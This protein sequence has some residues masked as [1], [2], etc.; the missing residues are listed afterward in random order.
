ML[1][2]LVENNKKILEPMF[3]NKSFSKTEA[4]ISRE[5][6]YDACLARITF[7]R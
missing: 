4:I 5:L 7:S 2:F 1:F 6:P 3:L